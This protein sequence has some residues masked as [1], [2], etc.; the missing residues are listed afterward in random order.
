M[1]ACA[2]G[3]T[4]TR[5]YQDGK[6]SVSGAAFKPNEQV[7][8]QLTVPGGQNT[9]LV[10]NADA[11]GAFRIDTGIDVPPGT[12]IQVHAQGDKGSKVVSTR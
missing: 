9:S 12:D 11:A 8:V 10:L 4:L 6:L 1:S 2:S 5:T 7:S 3:P